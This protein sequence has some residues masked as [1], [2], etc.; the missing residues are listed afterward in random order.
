MWVPSPPLQIFMVQRKRINAFSMC[1]MGSKISNFIDIFKFILFIFI[2]LVVAFLVAH[3]IL[4]HQRRRWPKSPNIL[5]PQLLEQL[6]DHA[7][8]F[9]RY[10]FHSSFLPFHAS[11]RVF[12]LTLFFLP[13]FQWNFLIGGLIDWVDFRTW[14][15]KALLDWKSTTTF[16]K[17]WEV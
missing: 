4:P 16:K 10:D 8:S 3:I 9:S 14:Q 12:I 1:R 5:L 11:H 6:G 7:I 13:C 17:Q 2:M 15:S